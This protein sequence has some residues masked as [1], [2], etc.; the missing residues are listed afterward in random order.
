ML[1]IVTVITPCLFIVI[2]MILYFLYD[3]S[4]LMT[5]IIATYMLFYSNRPNMLFKAIQ[6][7][8]VTITATV[9]DI[10]INKHLK[11]ECSPITNFFAFE[12]E[13]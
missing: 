5:F 7:K 13:C 9:V 4:L 3:L 11:K 10:T 1:Y 12:K 6:L 2:T 8:A